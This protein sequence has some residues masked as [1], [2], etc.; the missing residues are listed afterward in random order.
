MILAL[1]FCVI[2]A[3]SG[4]TING[5]GSGNVITET[6]NVNGVKQVSLEGIGNIVLQQG[7]QESL[8]IEAEDNI[9]PHI[10]SKVEGDKLTITYDTN[11]PAP[12]KDVTYYLTVKDLN[13]ISIS[14]AGKI[15]SNNFK[16]NTLD[17]ILSGAGE[18]NL[19]G[20][21]VKKLTVNMSGAGKLIVAGK[22][23]EQT[24]TISGAGD[25]QAKELESKTATITIDGA[26]NSIVNVTNVLNAI[27]NGVGNI[28]Y[29][30][31]PKVN[32]QV[33]GGG[34]IQKIA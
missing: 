15:Q 10:Q 22:A 13:S 20:L 2:I 9:M 25:Y 3:V 12:T 21:N 16:T 4:C 18:G 6:K 14:G 5:W 11:T 33:T 23:T 8:R 31:N 30:G 27:I 32:K 17:I 19:A 29:T 7:N 24:V 34:N 1:F 28:E 26:S